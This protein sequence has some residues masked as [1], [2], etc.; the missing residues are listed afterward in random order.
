[1][2]GN[3]VNYS[4]IGM[5]STAEAIAAALY[6]MGFEDQASAILDKFRWGHTFLELNDG[7]LREYAKVAE[8][9]QIQRVAVSYGLDSKYTVTAR[10]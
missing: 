7:L 5:L 1:M 6:I 10:R 9:D 2:A 4:R 8:P 3:P